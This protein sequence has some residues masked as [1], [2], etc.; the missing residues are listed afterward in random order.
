MQAT[1]PP[2]VHVRV[3]FD[4]A[5]QCGSPFSLRRGT[6]W[7][8]QCHHHNLH[9]A[10]HFN[11]KVHAHWQHGRGLPPKYVTDLGTAFGLWAVLVTARGPIDGSTGHCITAHHCSA[12]GEAL[13]GLFIQLDETTRPRLLLCTAV[14]STLKAQGPHTLVGTPPVS[15]VCDFIPP[16][17]PSLPPVS[18]SPAPKPLGAPRR[19]S[20]RSLLLLL[21][22][23]ASI[24]LLPLPPAMQSTCR[25]V[26]RFLPSRSP[27]SSL[28][29]AHLRLHSL[30]LNSVYPAQGFPT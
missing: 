14:A 30:S 19:F 12:A 13:A 25:C 29:A 22:S 16:L 28:L 26:V 4:F 23:I 6:Q 1:T 18:L 9:A 24:L 27:L 17:P 10:F 2:R 5:A 20:S 8:L 15:S 3:V 7:S 11:C 21:P